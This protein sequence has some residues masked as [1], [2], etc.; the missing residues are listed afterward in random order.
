M[1]EIDVYELES[2]VSCSIARTWGCNLVSWKVGG[3]ELMYC[4]ENLPAEARKI[5]GGGNPILFPAVGRTWDLSG[6]EPVAGR[7]RLSGS[8]KT[9]SMPSHGIVFRSEFRKVSEDR[10]PDALTALYELHIPTKVREESYPFDVALTQRFT[11]RH[12]SVELEAVMSNRGSSPA[13]MAFGYH[14]YFRVSNPEREGVEIHLPITKEM[15]LDKETILP[16]GE[17]ILAEPII[18]LKPE[19]YYDNVFAG[20]TGRRMSLVDRK[21]RRAVHV[22]YDESIEVLVL[23]SPDGSDFVCIE[24]WTRGLGAFGRL[25]EPGWE[26]G[27]LIPVLQPGESRSFKASFC[28]EGL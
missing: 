21:A 23:Y 18:K 20:L 6:G 9:Y 27:D 15:L 26:S 14:P 10:S 25:S 17:T 13:P 19:V 22:D 4:P 11:F 28:V 1:A 8:E 5:T 2:G 24:P 12:G 3:D 16:T 7:Y